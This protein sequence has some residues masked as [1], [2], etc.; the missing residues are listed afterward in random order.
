MQYNILNYHTTYC[1]DANSN[2]YPSS[3]DALQLWSC[4]TNNEQQW[5]YD[6]STQEIRNAASGYCLDANSN[7][8]PSNGDAL[9][10]WSCNTNNEQQWA[11]NA[12]TGPGGNT[13]YQLQN[14]AHPGYCI[15]ANSNSYPSSGDA[16]QL[17]SCDTNPEQLWP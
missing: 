7:S 12:V 3:G 8:Y 5:Y 17:W 14:V 15:D 16:L 6:P 4:N 10:L 9:Q 13:D 11:A 2:S 1:I